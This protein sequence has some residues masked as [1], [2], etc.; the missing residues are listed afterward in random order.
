MFK[1]FGIFT[2]LALVSIAALAFTPKQIERALQ[3][4]NWSEARGM[5]NETL[6]DHPESARAH[7]LDAYLLAAGDRNAQAAANELNQVVALDHNGDVKGS[8]LYGK[9]EQVIQ[10]LGHMQ[11]SAPLPQ[12]QP[13]APQVIV[14]TPQQS[15]PAPAPTPVQESGHGFFF[16][17]LMFV[18]V[19]GI[20]Y[21]G[22]RIYLS[23]MNT[24]TSSMMGSYP[25][26]SY[27]SSTRT[28]SYPSGTS[29]GAGTTI[30]NN[31]ST[32]SNSL[33][34]A[35]AVAGGVVA[36]ELMA[37][38]LTGRAYQGRRHSDSG[39]SD[40]NSGSGNTFARPAD[41]NSFSSSSGSSGLNTE[42]EDQ[43]MSSSNLNSDSWDSSSSSDS[44][45]CSSS[46]SSDSSFSSSDN[47]FS[48]SGDSS[49]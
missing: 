19:G 47:S 26:S 15:V 39:D 45:S 7:L 13:Q 5:I 29:S 38:A 40:Y 11:Y 3:Q 33:G 12:Y 22:R 34:T 37:D 44:D 30:I 18:I 48:S 24:S 25:S 16:W 28:T 23:A 35:A 41:D 31:G 6:R 27:S 4:Q 9:T 46:S 8:P 43:A 14:V 32:S 1:K 21:L 2:A 20:I 49:W 42:T 36:G 10:N 17:V